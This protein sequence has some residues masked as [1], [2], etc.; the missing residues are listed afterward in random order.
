MPAWTKGHPSPKNMQWIATAMKA[1]KER[2]WCPFLHRECVQP[3]TVYKWFI[4]N[5]RRPS[6]WQTRTFSQAELNDIPS[7]PQGAFGTCAFVGLSDS[8]KYRDPPY[9]KAI[10]AHDT[11]IRPGIS[12]LY[13]YEEKVGSR[14]DAI[15]YREATMDGE[16]FPPDYAGVKYVLKA[17]MVGN[18]SSHFPIWRLPML[19]QP[20]ADLSQRDLL[21]N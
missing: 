19:W 4:R 16:H 5:K 10:D 3:D 18:S 13:G 1:A 12:P 11:V 17:G 2:P 20:G 7:L 14:A 21:R 6:I 8:L 9:G 15:F